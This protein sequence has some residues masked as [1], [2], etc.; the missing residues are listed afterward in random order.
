[1]PERSPVIVI[2]G[3]TGV[4]KTA[5]AILLARSLHGEIIS[6]DSRQV[7]RLMD[8]GTAKPT[9]EE[10]AQAPQHLV[11]VLDPDQDLSLAEFQSMAYQRIEQV[12][13]QGKLPLLVGGTG[14][15]VHAVIE[16]WGIPDVA[17]HP[18]LRADIESFAEV[19]SSTALHAWLGEI[20]PP[21][22]FAIDYRNV[23]RVVRALEVYLVSGA[24][25]SQHQTRT[26][27]SYNFLVIGL[28]RPRDIL[29]A[30]IDQR[31]DEMIASGFV[32][33]V[34]QLV[35]RGYGRGLPSMS[36]LGYPEILSYLEGEFP[37]EE[38]VAAMKRETRRF[39]R[40]QA[41]WFRPTDPSIQ[42]FDLETT[43]SDTILTF[44]R[45]WLGDQAFTGAPSQS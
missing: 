38:A 5:L 7:Y 29:Y 9:P 30:R 35:A 28:T 18:E 39:I 45:G 23:R 2:V 3:P 10:R 34:R 1:M 36:S 20:D 15:Y 37:L 32:E 4:G 12:L 44:V 43:S 33:E 6:A 19:Y 17:P 16:G 14:Q 11:D 31:I 8:I 40:H 26:P 41:N 25:I 24:P 21:A 13:R 27:P 22:A 42:W